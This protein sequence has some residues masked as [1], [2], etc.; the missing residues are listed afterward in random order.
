MY[1]VSESPPLLYSYFLSHR[2]REH[3]GRV[4]EEEQKSRHMRKRALAEAAFWSI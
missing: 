4:R 1:Q 2:I 3:P